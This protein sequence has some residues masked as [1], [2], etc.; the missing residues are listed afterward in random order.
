[1][2]P[3]YL[4][5]KRVTQELY[6]VTGLPPQ[7]VEWELQGRYAAVVDTVAQTAMVGTVC[8]LIPPAG[9]ALSGY[10]FLS[11]RDPF[12]GRRLS[13]LEWGLA[14][15]G[16]VGSVAY[17][18]NWLHQ[19]DQESAAAQVLAQGRRQTAALEARAGEYEA[20][21]AGGLDE[22]DDL[23]YTGPGSGRGGWRVVGG[24]GGGGGGPI[25]RERALV[26]VPEG[27]QPRFP[28]IDG[29]RAYGQLTPREVDELKNF[30]QIIGK[31]VPITGGF[32]ETTYGLGL[33]AAVAADPESPLRAWLPEWRL[34]ELYVEWADVDIPQWAGL[35]PAERARVGEILGVPKID[36]KGYSLKRY[37][38]PPP[39]LTFYPDGRVEHTLWTWQ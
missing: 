21:L 22:G 18:A 23:R 8:A 32:A 38:T 17:T 11:G 37:P 29:G 14:A 20:G 13:D 39:G 5:T 36:Y 2:H 31:P 4:L 12:S 6:S 3:G 10:S 25:P 24:G 27:A 7:A 35:T 30:A 15:V 9:V 19:I 33:R 26:P 16:L 34:R 1:M 28:W